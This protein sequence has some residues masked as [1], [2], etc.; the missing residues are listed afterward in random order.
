MSLYY[1]C[2]KIYDDVNQRRAKNG[3]LPAIGYI[4][5]GIKS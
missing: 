5:K 3:F 4:A 1:P 2:P